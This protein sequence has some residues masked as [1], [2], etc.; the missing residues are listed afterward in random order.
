MGSI[1][2]FLS[3][4]YNIYVSCKVYI[5]QFCSL[6]SNEKYVSSLIGSRVPSKKFSIS[7]IKYTNLCREFIIIKYTRSRE[8]SLCFDIS[9]VWCLAHSC[10][11]AI[12]CFLLSFSHIR[13]DGDEVFLCFFQC[14]H[15]FLL[16]L[17]FKNI[18]L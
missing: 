17:R 12:I 10:F 5:I 11:F 1:N 16:F 15:I 4:T 2:F 8:R 14:N 18:S 9:L 3:Y 6:K 13:L 7:K